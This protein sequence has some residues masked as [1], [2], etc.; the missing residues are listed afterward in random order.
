[1]GFMGLG[2]CVYSA[3]SSVLYL[4]ISSMSVSLFTCTFKICFHMYSIIAT[5]IRYDEH[6]ENHN[7]YRATNV[8]NKGEMA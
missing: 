8:V 3:R 5:F 4:F 2:L 7:P 1:M 6:Q